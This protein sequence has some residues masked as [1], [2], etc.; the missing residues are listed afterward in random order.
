MPQKVSDTIDLHWARFGYSDLRGNGEHTRLVVSAM[1]AMGS[2]PP[3][4]DKDTVDVESLF[5]ILSWH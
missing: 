5:V 4:V 1:A 3:K 2:Y